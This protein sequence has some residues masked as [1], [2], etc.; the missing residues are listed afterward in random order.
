MAS[1][2]YQTVT[3]SKGK[4]ASPRDGAC[5]M[6]LASMLAGEA[7]SDHP[8]SVCP[9]IGAFLRAYNDWIDDDWRQDLYPYAST[10][11]GSRTDKEVE[12]VRADRLAAWVEQLRGRPR[13]RSVLPAWL[14]AIHSARR[15]PYDAL[16]ARAVG[17]IVR[18]TERSH[19]AALSLVDE[20]LE[21]RASKQ[22][23]PAPAGA[24]SI[25]ARR[26]AA[27]DKF[28]YGGARSHGPRYAA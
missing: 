7:F 9:V 23:F 4:H 24:E 3:L 19:K 26:Q 1:V 11:V 21:I 8:V 10:V 16:G 6:E 18:P 27:A 15:P 20:L 12:L 22:A 28:G 14:R 5:V 13:T 17:S 25:P 2:S